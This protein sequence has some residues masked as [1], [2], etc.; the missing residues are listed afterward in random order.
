MTTSPWT[1]RFLAAA[2]GTRMSLSVVPS[3]LLFNLFESNSCSHNAPYCQ[4]K[5]AKKPLSNAPMLQSVGGGGRG[6]VYDIRQQQRQWQC[7]SDRSHCSTCSSAQPENPIDPDC[8]SLGKAT[9]SKPALYRRKKQCGFLV[10]H[11]VPGRLDESFFLCVVFVHVQMTLNKSARFKS[12]L[13][14]L[15]MQVSHIVFSCNGTVILV[16]K[17]Q[18][19]SLSYL[20]NSHKLHSNKPDKNTFFIWLL[21]RKL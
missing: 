13:Q 6:V 7:D 9:D 19:G 8:P 17:Q 14:Q 11:C 1:V 4:V 10:A 20:W 12:S 3:S 5:R 16:A 2:P 15:W 21:Q 18:K